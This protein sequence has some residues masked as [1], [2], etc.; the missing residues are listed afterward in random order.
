VQ[1]GRGSAKKGFEMRNNDNETTSN[2]Q[3]LPSK[4]D[5]VEL[6]R[7]AFSEFGTRALWNVKRL[8]HPTVTQILAITR[9]LRTEGDMA[10]RHLAEQIERAARADL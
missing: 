10:A 9:Q 4:D 6:Y 7:R 1:S 3:E 2:T 8:D 5:L